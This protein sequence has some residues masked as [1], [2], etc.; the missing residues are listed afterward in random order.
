MGRSFWGNRSAVFPSLA[1]AGK[2]PEKPSVADLLFLTER[3]DMI[4][5]C[6]YVF[7]YYG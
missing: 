1:T 7:F 3:L 2:Q 5:D 6:F 4:D